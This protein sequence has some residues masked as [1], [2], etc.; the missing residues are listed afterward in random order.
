[1]TRPWGSLLVGV[2]VVVA[3]VVANLWI[4]GVICMVFGSG[5]PHKLDQ[6]S[7]VSLIQ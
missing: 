1:M 4:S 6:F 7:L 5:F 3:S 2:V